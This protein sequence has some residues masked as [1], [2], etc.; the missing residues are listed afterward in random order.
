[1]PSW[2]IDVIRNLGRSEREY[3]VQ[4]AKASY[5]RREKRTSDLIGKLVERAGQLLAPGR[6]R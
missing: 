5:E 1:M 3:W 6:R 2:P 4:F